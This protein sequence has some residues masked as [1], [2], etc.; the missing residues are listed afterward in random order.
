MT[1]WSRL[2]AD[3]RVY[4]IALHLGNLAEESKDIAIILFECG[5]IIRPICLKSS[6]VGRELGR[7]SLHRRDPRVWHGNCALQ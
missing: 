1:K 4:T 6:S 7:Y 2:V 5:S 3:G